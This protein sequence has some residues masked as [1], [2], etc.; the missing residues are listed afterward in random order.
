MT[1]KGYTG[2]EMLNAEFTD[3]PSLIPGWLW[4]GD[5]VIILGAPKASKSILTMQMGNA[6]T[7]G[8]NWLEE[9][10]VIKP[11]NVLYIQ[12]EGKMSETISRYKKMIKVVNHDP[13]RLRWLYL[14]HLPM[15]KEKSAEGLIGLI[16][17]EFG[18]WTPNVIIF[19]PLYM[20]ATGSLKDDDVA[21][22]IVQNINKVKLHYEATV[23]INHH[24]HRSKFDKD[25]KVVH[26]G[27]NSIFG[28]FVWQAWP[29]QI[30]RIT[31]DSKKTRTIRCNTQRSGEVVRNCKLYFN[32]P[33]PL[34]FEINED[35]TESQ[36]LVFKIIEKKKIIT[37]E[38]IKD[39]IDLSDSTIYKCLRGL[40]DDKKIKKLDRG[41]YG[42]I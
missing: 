3:P 20:L 28:S 5:N 12:A 13:K 40:I 21:G 39:I 9:Y 7:K 11:C 36:H 6:L 18:T 31:Y 29:D 17:K 42:L 19:D 37:V 23:I 16:M 8:D 38:D 35:T 1:K 27:D 30:I 2:Q 26:E 32:E 24:E 25:H 14:P 33:N 4:E 34:F 41:E 22:S 15:D 10:D